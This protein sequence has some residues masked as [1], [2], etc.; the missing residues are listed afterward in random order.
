MPEDAF[1]WMARPPLA[2]PF[3]HSLRYAVKVSKDHAKGGRN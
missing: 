3:A 2:A 1:V